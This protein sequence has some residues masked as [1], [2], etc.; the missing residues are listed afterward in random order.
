MQEN[1]GVVGIRS[2]FVI[3]IP[4]IK[5]APLESNIILKEAT[6]RC[7]SFGVAMFFFKNTYI[8]IP[9]DIK[10]F[11]GDDWL[12]CQNKKRKR[13][14]YFI[15]NQKIYHYG[16][17]SSADKNLNPYSKK[18][19]KLYRKYTRNLL[20]KF[21]NFESV[22]KGFRLTFLGINILYHYSKKH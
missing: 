20:E 5:P 8:E 13:K 11:W 4:E 19:A 21:F 6:G 9:E 1:M 14:N 7:T 15:V 17:L 2:D 12:Y 22:Y 3:N 10:I 18:D 16:S